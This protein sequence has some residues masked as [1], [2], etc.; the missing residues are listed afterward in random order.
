MFRLQRHGWLLAG[1]C[2]L[3]CGC[4]FVGSRPSSRPVPLPPGADPGEIYNSGASPPPPPGTAAVVPASATAGRPAASAQHAARLIA[5]KREAARADDVKRYQE[6]QGQHRD[7]SQRENATDADRVQMK[8]VRAEADGLVAAGRVGPKAGARYNIL[9]LSGGGAHGAYSAGV[10]CGWT[11]SGCRP[12]FDVVT[13]V[14]AG[15]LV[16]CLAFAGP[17]YD[18]DLRRAFTAVHRRDVFRIKKVPPL[19][20]GTDSLT[21]NAPLRGMIRDTP[22]RRLLRGDHRRPRQRPAAVHRHHEHRHPAVR[23]LGHGGDRVRAAGRTRRH[24]YRK[25]LLASAS[26]PGSSA[27]RRS[28]W[29]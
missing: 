15:A 6:L 24:L 10:I 2:L 18:A 8:A 3:A 25:V 12:E 27:G 20:I 26:V 11:A 17:E 5:A 4:S 13:G 16:A 23:D 29:R 7:L 21:T 22:T 28:R 9:T 1:L 19:G 14:S